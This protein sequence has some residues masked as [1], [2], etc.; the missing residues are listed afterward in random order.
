MPAMA[1]TLGR[2]DGEEAYDLRPATRRDHGR[3]SD[4]SGERSPNESG[5]Q[6]ALGSADRATGYSWRSGCANPLSRRLNR[7]SRTWPLQNQRENVKRS[8][9]LETRRSTLANVQAG[10]TPSRGIV[11]LN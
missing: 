7:L 2:H 9:S 6:T 11:V 10:K 1:P 8:A 3:A 4:G 5:R